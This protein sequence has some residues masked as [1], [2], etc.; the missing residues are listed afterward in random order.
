MFGINPVEIAKGE[1]LKLDINENGVPDALEA[2]DAAE[3]ACD[4]LKAFFADFNAE[5]ASALLQLA[6]SVRKPEKKWKGA[7]LDE[8]AAKVV[9]IGPAL[10]KAKAAMEGMEAELKKSK[11]K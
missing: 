7:Q 2:L 11:K 4:G 8:L 5:E 1:V 6:N 10:D 3:A 9:L